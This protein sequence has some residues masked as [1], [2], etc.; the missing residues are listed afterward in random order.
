M[1]LTLGPEL[2]SALNAFAQK[3]GIAPEQAALSV[4]SE[5]LLASDERLKPRDEW[6]RQLLSIASDCGVALSDEAV[7]SEGIYE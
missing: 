5:R 6:E 4:L 1:V 2:E 3:Q 7:S